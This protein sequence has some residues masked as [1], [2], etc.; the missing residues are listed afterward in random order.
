MMVAV[1][2][3]EHFQELVD[4]SE[5]KLVLIDCYAPWCGPCEAL[6]PSLQK[7]WMEYDLPAERIV[8]ATCDM[9][10][11]AAEIQ[12]LFPENGPVIENNGCLPLFLVVRF[13]ALTS[14]I[15]GVDAPQLLTHIA[16]NIPEKPNQ[17]Q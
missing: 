14:H 8:V 4:Q 11:Y 3:P 5:S 6:K 13:K 17:D 16:T 12:G 7:V 10:K 15:S 1:E 9:V 2:S